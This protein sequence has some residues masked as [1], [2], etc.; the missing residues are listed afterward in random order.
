MRGTTRTL[1][2]RQRLTA[3]VVG[4]STATAALLLTAPAASATHATP[5]PPSVA[6]AVAN[7]LTVTADTA[8]PDVII[9]DP[10]LW[11]I[12]A[13][14][15]STSLENAQA[16][17]SLGDALTTRQMLTSCLGEW[18]AHGE[19]GIGGASSA[20]A[21][22]LASIDV[23]I[24]PRLL[25]ALDYDP[26]ASTQPSISDP[27]SSG[28]TI[29]S[30]GEHAVPVD[31]STAV[32]APATS[33]EAGSPSSEEPTEGTAEVA[34]E[35]SVGDGIETE[36]H[37]EEA[38]SATEGKE[39]VQESTAWNHVGADGFVAPSSGTITSPF[40]DGREH[41][42]IDIAN[43]L[44]APIVAVADGE[45]INAGPAQG[46]GLWVR[47]RHDDGTI[48]TYGHNNGNLVEVGQRVKAGQKIAS[49]G[50]RGNSS[51]PHLH[52]EVESSDGE[53]IDPLAWLAQRGASIIGLG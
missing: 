2:V 48:T 6:A 37:D 46:Y 42:G 12:V 44:G 53:K 33:G 40:G 5:P 34:P 30:V 16:N 22:E 10:G 20:C 35:A 38:G 39:S 15:V 3:L 52:F 51:G 21:N 26:P 32:E 28:A 14:I 23:S 24:G 47:I 50:N 25:A 1:S 7:A 19:P 11:Q 31:E 9:V 8:N 17:D 36:A 29:G 27:E 49:I 45:V 13:N 43:T 4:G 18:A 41:G